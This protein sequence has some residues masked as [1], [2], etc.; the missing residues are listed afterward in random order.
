VTKFSKD[1]L[2]CLSGSLD[3][4]IIL[5]NPY[6][7]TQIKS[8]SGP[9]NQEILD[10]AISRDNNRFASVGG[11]KNAF[12]WDVATGKIIRKLTGHDSRINTCWWQLI[13]IG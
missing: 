6:K 11:D 12:I 4:S 7:G 9:H 8:Y 5:W 2:F 3:R 10:I 1:G 13:N